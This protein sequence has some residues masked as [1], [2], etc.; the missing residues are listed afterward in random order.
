MA[1][2]L[3]TFQCFLHLKLVKWYKKRPGHSLFGNDLGAFY[4]PRK[5]NLMTLTRFPAAFSSCVP[6]FFGGFPRP[7][8]C[9]NNRLAA[10][11][12][13]RASRRRRTAGYPGPGRPHRSKPSAPG[14]GKERPPGNNGSRLLSTISPAYNIRNPAAGSHSPGHSWRTFP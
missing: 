2:G 5:A 8:R 14:Q 12:G 1:V 3:I 6:G 7:C 9:W 4:R 10:P 11:L 13:E